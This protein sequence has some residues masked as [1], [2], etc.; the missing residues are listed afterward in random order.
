MMDEELIDLETSVYQCTNCI[1]Q[2][3]ERRIPCTVVMG[4]GE[5]PDQCLFR[6]GEGLVEWTC[7]QT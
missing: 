6:D 2:N 1:E 5:I 3:H 4:A 7:L